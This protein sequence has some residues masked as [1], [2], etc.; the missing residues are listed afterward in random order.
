MKNGDECAFKSSYEHFFP[1]LLRQIFFKC[2]DHSLAEDITQE[3]FLKVWTHR[4]SISTSKP[5]FPFVARI[6][7]NLMLDRFRKNKTGEKY[8]DQVIEMSHRHNPEPDDCYQ[9]KVLEEA[10]RRAVADHLPEKCRRVFLLSRIERMSN[11]EIAS[12]LNVSKKTVE[13]QLYHA[14]KVIRKKCSQYL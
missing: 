3:A 7:H 5:L 6:A 12:L 13:N 10:I 4:T 1:I 9:H 11:A 14:L 2:Q 8:R